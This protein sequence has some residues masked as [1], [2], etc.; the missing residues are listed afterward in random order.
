MP[1][2]ATKSS[3]LDGRAEVVSYARDTSVFYLRVRLTDKPGYRSR[4]ID[5]VSTLPEAVERAL[6]TYMELGAPSSPKPPRRGTKHGT[7]VAKR[8][9]LLQHLAEYLAEETERCEAGV[10]KPSTLKNKTEALTK[11]S[12]YGNLKKY[13]A[14]RK[15]TY[16]HIH[17]NPANAW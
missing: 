1:L 2:L 3:V 13:A 9:A 8:A 15:G 7:K 4:R 5:G 14:R 11:L 10:I 16:H 12:R 17:Q 6:D